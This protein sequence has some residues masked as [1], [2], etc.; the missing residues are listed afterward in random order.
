M[1]VCVFVCGSG[2]VCI[3]NLQIVCVCVCLFCACVWRKVAFVLAKFFFAALSQCVCVP[4]TPFLL[5]VIDLC[6]VHLLFVIY[7]L[8]DSLDTYLKEP[9]V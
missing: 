8:R 2:C 9:Y 3:G 4:Q 6:D 5:F 7:L 1:C